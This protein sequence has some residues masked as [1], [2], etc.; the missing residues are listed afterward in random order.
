[1]NY[2]L[3]DLYTSV[4]IR[5][6]Q[7]YVKLSRDRY[8]VSRQENYSQLCIVDFWGFAPCSLINV[9]VSEEHVAYVFRVE[10]RRVRKL[11]S[12]AKI[13]F[14]FRTKTHDM[15]TLN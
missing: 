11:M 6:Q 4:A 2:E 1:M 9:Y 5:L 12:E 8:I 7:S 14:L 3:R 13:A 15:I 10:A